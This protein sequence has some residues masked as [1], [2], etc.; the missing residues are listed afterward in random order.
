ME[1][2]EEN[3]GILP[4]DA[5]DDDED[6]RV[7]EAADEE[8]PEPRLNE[9]LLLDIL[10]ALDHDPGLWFEVLDSLFPRTEAELSALPAWV[11]PD[12]AI[13]MQIEAFLEQL[14]SNSAYNT[15]DDLVKTISKR[16]PLSFDTIS[17]L[18]RLAPSC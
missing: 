5:A 8:E 18:S 2:A 17:C 16:L 10:E 6:S 13:F 12:D 14:R 1:G 9:L 11:C 4:T 15:H 3:G 7:E